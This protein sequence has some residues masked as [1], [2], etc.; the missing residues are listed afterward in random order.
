[1]RRGIVLFGLAVCFSLLFQANSQAGESYVFGVHPFKNPTKLMKMFTP[2]RQHLSKEL[3]ADVSFR[4]AK[5][6][7]SH[8]QSLLNGDVDISYL[9][10]SLFAIINSEHPGKIRI[11]AAILNKGK[12]TFKGVIVARQD[13]NINS[14]KDLENL[15][16]AGAA[17]AIVGRALY[18]GKL[19]P[20][21]L[22]NHKVDQN[23]KE[24]C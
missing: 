20:D 24:P 10:P 22:F 5:D 16:K 6:Y 19:S 1:M 3:G 21:E 15:K 7:D 23:R 18:E 11:A 12:P 17:G 8:M 14:L 2:L 4:S 13:S 9:G